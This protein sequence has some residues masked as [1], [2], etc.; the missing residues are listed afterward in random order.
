MNHFNR[1]VIKN[2]HVQNKL[3]SLLKCLPS[4]ADP[5]MLRLLIKGLY[6][7]DKGNPSLMN[8]MIKQF[9]V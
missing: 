6:E 8:H 5:T 4:N 1:I 9:S 2:Q 3:D 7:M